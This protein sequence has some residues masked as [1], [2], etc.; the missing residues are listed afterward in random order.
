MTEPT[1]GRAAA[2]APGAPDDW[3]LPLGSGPADRVAPTPLGTVDGTAGAAVD[4]RGYVVPAPGGFGVDWWIG[5][6]DRWHLPAEEAAVRQRLVAAAPVVETTLRIPG[7][8][9]VHRAYAV[10]L[11]TADGGG[12]G[13][14][15]EV[16]NRSAVP[17]ALALAVRPFD[18]DGPVALSEV[19]LD[20]V[21]LCVDGTPALVL[22]RVPNRAVASTA[23]AGDVRH[24]VTGGLAHGAEFEP[25]S[26]PEGRAHAAVIVPVPHSATFRAL[27]P[28]GDRE[29]AAGLPPVLPGADNVADGWT[30]QA[31]RAT[32]VVVPDPSVQ[33]AADPLVASLLLAS[34]SHPAGLPDD[35]SLDVTGS[36]G[37]VVAVARALSD[38]GLS[39]EAGHLFAHTLARPEL[40]DP[41]RSWRGPGRRGGRVD[42]AGDRDALVA[43]VAGLADHHRRSPDR[44][45]AEAAVDLVAAVVG[46]AAAEQRRRSRRT[47]D[48]GA[49]P[50]TT[51]SLFA[52][53]A[54][55]L[56]AAGEPRAATDALAIA[57]RI[58][59]APARE[60]GPDPADLL[61]AALVGRSGT[62]TWVDG[63]GRADPGAT[64]RFASLVRASLLRESDGGIQLLPS[65]PTA[66]L[67]QGVEVHGAPTRFG[68]VSFA[69]RWHADRPAL[70]WEVDAPPGSPDGRRATTHLTCPGLDPTWSSDERRSEALLAPVPVPAP[71]TGAPDGD[72]S[73]GKG[74]VI[75]GLQIGMRPPRSEG[76]HE[77]AA[78]DPAGDPRPTPEDEQP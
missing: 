23:A 68:P 10:R 54:L 76:H 64:A 70:L 12:E 59:A 61:R 58:D 69:L 71:A 3:V 37:D 77:P 75:G 38:L 9:A 18:F 5:A 2:P 55:L 60:P 62:G 73:G 4:A 78:T 8:E 17:F 52:D 48:A 40:G 25:V 29:T 72:G 63:D 35:L 42:A 45:L 46:L 27:V 34:T 11:S 6:D 56:A 66:W 21:T 14:V 24:V 65:F 30:T 43:L 20:G 33:E 22:P 15:I 53:G 16:E 19:A 50:S 51:R 57:D 39:G 1:H 74:V 7:G 13:V 32:R 36:L 44:P 41:A 67:G 49:D 28:L 47:G 26:C 31:R